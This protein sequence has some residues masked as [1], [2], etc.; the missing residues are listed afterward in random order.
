MLFK[1]FYVPTTI[2]KWSTKRDLSERK[3]SFLLFSYFLKLN[4]R[5]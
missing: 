5:A 1:E 2:Y 3:V 4:K